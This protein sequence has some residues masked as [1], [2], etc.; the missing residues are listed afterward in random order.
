[1]SASFVAY[2]DES[3][4]TGFTFKA[5][6]GGS[7]CWLVLSAVVVRKNFDLQ[8]V[9]D[10][11]ALR[12]KLGKQPKSVLHFKDQWNHDQKVFTC[13]EFAKMRMRAISILAYKPLIPNKDAYEKNTEMLYRYMCR[14]LLER[15]SW[16]CRDRRDPNVGDGT[17]E[18]IFSNRTRM[19]YSDL[20]DYFQKLKDHGNTK[21][22]W[23]VIDIANVR[24][25]PHS[26]MAGLQVADYVASSS[27]KAVELN[28][29]GMV[30]NKYMKMFKAVFYRYRDHPKNLFGYGLKFYPNLETIKPSLPHLAELEGL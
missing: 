2:I 11:K 17:V 27:W 1:M 30:E 7:S 28:K 10:M 5:N 19:S 20:T 15:I 25:V 12:A 3:G 14:L 18:L 4:D 26:Q 22:E 6:A 23:S 13:T 24:S 16:L 9:Q 8:L 21:I 29:F